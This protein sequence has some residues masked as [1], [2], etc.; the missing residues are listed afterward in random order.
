MSVSQ[1]A[2][3]DNDTNLVNI[4][5]TVE[6]DGINIGS[7]ANGVLQTGDVITGIEVVGSDGTI[8]ESVEVE[9]IFNVID[10][11]LAVRAGDTVNF[12]LERGGD[13]MCVSLGEIS[14]SEYTLTW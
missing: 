8:K 12:T 2:V 9:R 5:E 13:E 6:V 14:Q 3:L 10:T 1:R 11:V 4:V 7:P